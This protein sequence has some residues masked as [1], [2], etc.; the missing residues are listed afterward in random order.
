MALLKRFE[1]WLL[2]ILIGGGL[3]YVINIQDA[4]QG[5]APIRASNPID[6]EKPAPPPRFSLQKTTITRDGDHFL[7]EIKIHCRNE[8]GQTLK[9]SPHDTRLLAAGGQEIPAFFLPFQ[10]SPQ[11]P[12]SSEADVILRYWLSQD[13]INGPISLQIDKDSIPIKIGA[14]EPDA[15]PDKQSRSFTGTNWNSKA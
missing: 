14:Y 2:L 3:F 8:H 1:L 9:L 11:V 6:S 15:L 10:P 5:R 4:D 13:D 7:A 12:E